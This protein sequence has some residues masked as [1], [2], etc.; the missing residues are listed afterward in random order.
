VHIRDNEVLEKGGSLKPCFERKIFV[1]LSVGKDLQKTKKEDSSGKKT[2]R[3]KKAL[4][5]YFFLFYQ[6]LLLE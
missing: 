1:I 4:L 2:F 5:K 6:T 3:N